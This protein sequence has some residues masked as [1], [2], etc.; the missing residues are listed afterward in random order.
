MTG[1]GGCHESRAYLSLGGEEGTETAASCPRSHNDNTG[2]CWSQLLQPLPAPLP[3][4]TCWASSCSKTFVPSK[5]L[6]WVM[7]LLWAPTR[8]F[9][10]SRQNSDMESL[11]KTLDFQ[12]LHSFSNSFFFLEEFGTGPAIQGGLTKAG[13]EIK[14]Q[15]VSC[16]IKRE[17]DCPYLLRV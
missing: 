5:F 7:H 6:P 2:E 4:V 15:E 17:Y 1:T 10:Q 16:R 14:P 3:L 13:T 9:G 12:T 8:W 11:E